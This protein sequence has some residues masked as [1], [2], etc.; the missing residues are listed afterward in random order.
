MTVSTK[1]RT[2]E[3]AKNDEKPRLNIVLRGMWSVFGVS[4]YDHLYFVQKA[5]PNL[6]AILPKSECRDVSRC[7]TVRIVR[8]ISVETHT[9]KY[10]P[11][12]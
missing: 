3:S 7:R 2:W 10:Y 11:G 6:Q 4:K 5:A 12:Q 9:H 8:S 1:T